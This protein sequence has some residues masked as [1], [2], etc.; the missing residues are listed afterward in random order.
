VV[1]TVRV[2]LVDFFLWFACSLVVMS[3]LEHQVHRWLMHRNNF[4]STR[5]SSFKTIFREHAVLHHGHYYKEFDHEP[6]DYGRD[7]NLHLSLSRGLVRTLPIWV[8][9]S[10]VS[11]PG[12]IAFVSVLC[13]HHWTWNLIH[14]EMHKPHKRFFSN[15]P[16]YKF[17]AR[18]HYLHHKYPGK[19]FNVVLPFADYVLNTHARATEEDFVTMRKLGILKNHRNHQLSVLEKPTTQHSLHITDSSLLTTVDADHSRA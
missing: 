19:N 18:H 8:A 3:F 16:L 1:E 12:A 9:L 7:L 15:W 10:F 14:E 4:L 11:I 5:F 2:F 17:L 13:M 6:D